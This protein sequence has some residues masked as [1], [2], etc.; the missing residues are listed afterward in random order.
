MPA[1][2]MCSAK[3]LQEPAHDTITHASITFPDGSGTQTNHDDVHD[4]LSLYL[5][6]SV[7]LEYSIG[8]HFDNSKMSMQTDSSLKCLQAMLP[9]SEISHARFRHN[10]LIKT[11]EV[12]RGCHEIDWVGQEIA[13]GDVQLT[14]LKQVRR[15]SMVSAAQPHLREDPE[16]LRTIL[17]QLDCRLGVYAETEM[18]GMLR[19]GDV[20]RTV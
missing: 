9:E 14:V 16:I 1:L 10:F 2:M 12:A 11:P 4:R 17:D 13:V 20:I 6:R 8:D 7:T 18:T 5:G 19:V 3:Y 15:C